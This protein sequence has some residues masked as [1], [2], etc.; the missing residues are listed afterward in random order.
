M[1]RQVVM[2]LTYYGG[3]R[4]TE[5]MVLEMEKCKSMSE[6]VYM[7]RT[8]VQNSVVISGTVGSWCLKVGQIVLQISWIYTS[9]MSR[10][11]LDSIR[12]GY[13][14]QEMMWDS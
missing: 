4:D 8:C 12:V 9:R 1:V 6:G 5:I 7:L 3:L 2:C 14:G 10:S 13:C 11:S